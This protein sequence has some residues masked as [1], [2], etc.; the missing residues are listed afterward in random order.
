MACNALALSTFIPPVNVTIL[1]GAL[2][3]NHFRHLVPCVIAGIKGIA[4]RLTIAQLSVSLRMEGKSGPNCT[5]RK[6]AS[7]VFSGCIGSTDKSL[8][9]AC[10]LDK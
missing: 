4:Y 1:V 9:V 2:F 10:I 6:R 3:G 5:F 7:G 8:I